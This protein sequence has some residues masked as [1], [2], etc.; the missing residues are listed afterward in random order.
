VAKF[1]NSYP[2]IEIK[3]EIKDEDSLVTNTPITLKVSLVAEDD[4]EEEGS[5]TAV[6]GNVS[7]FVFVSSPAHKTVETHSPGER[8]IYEMVD[9]LVAHD[10]PMREGVKDA[11]EMELNMMLFPILL[12]PVRSIVAHFLE[13]ERAK[14]QSPFSHYIEQ[15]ISMLRLFFERI[16]SRS[17][18]RRRS[19]SARC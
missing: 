7:H 13:N 15:A 4:D 2:A 18:C 10:L 1:V 11:L 14:P 16:G 9:L 12:K 6:S 17:T 19:V 5:K 8:K 3:H